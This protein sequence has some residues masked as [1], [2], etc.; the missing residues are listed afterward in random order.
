MNKKIMSNSVWMM[1]EKIISIFGVIFVTSFIAK[2]V[3]PDIFGQIAF[4]T[5]LFQIA[6]IIAQFGSDV[7]I[8]KRVSK[9]EGSG[10][11]LINSTIS[12]RFLTYMLIAIPVILVSHKSGDVRGLVFILACCISCLFSALDVVSIYY[13][14]RLESKKIP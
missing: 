7:I 2:Y 9:S 3:G 8:F 11:K 14:A 12:L 10:I 13:D 1:A 5:S 6:M 4:A